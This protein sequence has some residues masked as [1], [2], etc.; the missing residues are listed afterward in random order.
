MFEAPVQYVEVKTDYGR[1]RGL[2]RN[3]LATF[4][5]IRNAGAVSRWKRFKAAPPLKVSIGGGLGSA[6]SRYCTQ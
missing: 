2:K 1:V 5:G 4:K 6:Y 3:G